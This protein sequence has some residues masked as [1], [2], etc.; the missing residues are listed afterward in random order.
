MEDRIRFWKRLTRQ[1]AELVD[2]RK[3]GFYRSSET[4][5]QWSRQVSEPCELQ[6]VPMDRAV[7]DSVA[8]IG[9]HTSKSEALIQSETALNAGETENY[10]TDQLEA[11][12]Q[13]EHKDMR[14][15]WTQEQVRHEDFSIKV[16]KNWANM[17]KMSFIASVLQCLFQ[18][19]DWHSTRPRI[20]HLHYKMKAVEVYD[21][22]GEGLQPRYRTR[23]TRCEPMMDVAPRLQ[24]RRH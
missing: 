10:S 18:M 7:R 9:N 12:H 8:Q 14:Y 1:G 23:Q 11:R 20:P 17:G 19:Q 16:E 4:C 3:V 22:S 21:G 15:F 5:G 2:P 13:R 6:F 24:S